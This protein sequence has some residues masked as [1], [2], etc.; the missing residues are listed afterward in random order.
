VERAAAHILDPQNTGT[1]GAAGGGG[2]LRHFRTSAEREAVKALLATAASQ[3]S[4]SKL[5][6]NKAGAGKAGP[7]KAGGGGAGAGAGRGRGRGRGAR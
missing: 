1:V 6:N 2:L 4:L 3:A 7:G 5:A